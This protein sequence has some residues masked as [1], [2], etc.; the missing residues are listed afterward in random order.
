MGIFD[1]LSG[2]KPGKIRTI[3][4]KFWKCPQ[5][6]A[7]LRKGMAGFFGPG[8][9]IMG[10]ATC[11]KCG[12]RFSQQEVYGG[13]YD[14]T[15][16]VSAEVPSKPCPFKDSGG[17]CV[18]PGH[19]EQAQPC[20]FRGDSHQ[21]GCFVYPIHAAKRS[22]LE[23][24]MKR[25]A[26]LEQKA[27]GRG[28]CKMCEKTTT[29]IEADLCSSCYDASIRAVKEFERTGRRGGICD[30]CNA[31]VPSEI[32]LAFMNESGNMIECRECAENSIKK[33]GYIV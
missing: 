22:Q 16:Q 2:K 14:V 7:I 11:G 18:P 15:V 5:C 26:Q 24:R 6:G 17:K 31:E 19:P 3:D 1:R 23:E 10:T 27:Q 20:S 13:K 33:H 4:D 21:F 30:W 9:R 12:A 28:V 8:A 32:G 29:L 25:L